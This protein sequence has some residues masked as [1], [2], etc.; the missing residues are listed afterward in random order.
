M[1]NVKLL[2]GVNFMLRCEV[3]KKGE[4]DFMKALKP[5]RKSF[6]EPLGKVKGHQK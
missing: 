2:L 6:Y 4:Y 5:G 1:S 3:S